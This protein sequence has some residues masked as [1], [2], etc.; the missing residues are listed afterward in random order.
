MKNCA[1]KL[2]PKRAANTWLSANAAP[3][4]KLQ[5]EKP[6]GETIDYDRLLEAW[7]QGRAR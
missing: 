5:N 3:W 1:P 6:R 4:S 2:N 7:R